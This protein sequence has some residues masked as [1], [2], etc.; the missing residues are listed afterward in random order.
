MKIKGVKV[1]SAYEEVVVFPRTTGP[2]LVFTARA[3]SDYDSFNK[4]CPQPEPPSIVYAGETT[5]R[6]NVED[7][8][9]RKAF[10]EWAEQQSHWMVLES[11]KATEGLEWETVKYEDPTTWKNYQNEM[12]EAGLTDAEQARIIKIVSLVNGIDQSKIDEATNSFL[13]SRAAQLSNE[14]SPASAPT[15]TP[16]GEP[17][18]V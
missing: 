6:K 10:L 8:S 1:K 12:R 16:S 9:Y 13:A 5:P 7:P 17:V 4:L 3:V 18:N 14:N 11:L 2:N 15:A